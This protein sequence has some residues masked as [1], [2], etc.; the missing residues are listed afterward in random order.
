MPAKARQWRDRVSGNSTARQKPMQ[1]RPH[2]RRIGQTIERLRGILGGAYPHRN[3]ALRIDKQKPAF[4]IRQARNRTRL[5]ASKYYFGK[6]NLIQ[7][8]GPQ[9]GIEYWQKHVITNPEFDPN[10]ECFVIL[11][12]NMDGYIKGHVF[13]DGPGLLSLRE[14]AYDML[15][16]I[17]PPPGL[18]AFVILQH[19]VSDEPIPTNDDIVLLDELNEEAEYQAAKV[20][21]Y[22]LVGQS[23]CCCIDPDTLKLTYMKVA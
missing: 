13:S 10:H 2:A 7:Y 15:S 23:E 22:I 17:M 8:K 16:G 12:I 1:L 9:T 4:A 20:C 21:D 11:W 19:N 3:P 18:D 5:Y 14:H 6:E